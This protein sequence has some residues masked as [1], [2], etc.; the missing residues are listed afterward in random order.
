MEA[1][2]PEAAEL[3]AQRN[4]EIDR[5]SIEKKAAETSYTV[6]GRIGSLTVPIMK[7]I[8]LNWQMGISLLTGF[9]S[10]EITV[11]TLRRTVPNRKR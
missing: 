4:A 6:I 2:S 1:R 7:P 8:G 11:S 10:K 9:I 5:L 3:A